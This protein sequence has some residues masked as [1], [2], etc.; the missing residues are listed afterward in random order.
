MTANGDK[1]SF[2]GDENILELDSDNGFTT[3]WIYY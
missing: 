3:L 1:V 2:W